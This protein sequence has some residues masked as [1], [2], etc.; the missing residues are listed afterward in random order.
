MTGKIDKWINGNVGL[1][2]TAIKCFWKK[3][4]VRLKDLSLPWGV[5]RPEYLRQKQCFCASW[6]C[7]C[8]KWRPGRRRYH[9]RGVSHSLRPHTNSHPTSA[10]H[11]WVCVC[12]CVW[13]THQKHWTAQSPHSQHSCASMFK[14]THSHTQRQICAKQGA[15]IQAL[16]D[17]LPRVT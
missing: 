7:L 10:A 8:D 6:V 17:D 5:D 11:G 4:L 14:W 2:T 12:V 9:V 15:A 3:N 16:G 1:T 13:D